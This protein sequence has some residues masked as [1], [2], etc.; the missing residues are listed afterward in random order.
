MKLD[1]VIEESKVSRK[2]ARITRK[3]DEFFIENLSRSNPLS[4]NGS[5]IKE[6]ALLFEGD[7]VQIGPALFRFSTQ[8][9]AA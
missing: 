1:F 3:G 9:A 2:H 5:L 4:V 6:P 8:E 7:K